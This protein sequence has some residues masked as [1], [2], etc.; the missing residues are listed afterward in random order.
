MDRTVFGLCVCVLVLVGFIALN[1]RSSS[2]TECQG[3]VLR[4]MHELETQQTSASCEPCATAAQV[5]TPAS[6]VSTE[7]ESEM[8]VCRAELTTLQRDMDALKAKCKR[9]DTTTPA[10]TE[11]VPITREASTISKQQH[12]FTLISFNILEGGRP[13]RLEAITQWISSQRPQAVVLTECNGFTETSLRALAAKWGHNH[14]RIAL[15]SS[16]FLV[17]L[18]SQYPFAKEPIVHLQH[19]RHALIEATID[20]PINGPATRHLTIFGLHLT[21]AAGSERLLEAQRVVELV[22]PY[23]QEWALVAGDFNS[24]SSKDSA[25]YRNSMLEHISNPNSNV[26]DQHSAEDAKVTC[27]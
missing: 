8:R 13:N 14:S 26:N 25:E 15:T 23:L 7:C 27:L 3:N 20:V 6:E 17:S 9:L 11:N 24:L 10:T 19:F 5:Q 4:L 21:P 12:Q 2:D 1:P 22:K 16:G 18:T